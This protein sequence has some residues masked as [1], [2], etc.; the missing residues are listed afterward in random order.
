MAV[1]IIRRRS[2]RRVPT[3]VRR[4]RTAVIAHRDRGAIRHPEC[5]GINDGP[6]P[7]VDDGPQL[8]ALVGDPAELDA[9]FGTGGKVMTNTGGHRAFAVALQSD[10]KIVVAGEGT[11]ARPSASR[12][13]R[14]SG[15]LDPSFDGDGIANVDVGILTAQW[16][17][18]SSPT[19]RSWLSG[20]AA[21]GGFCCEAGDR[22]AD[23]P[24]GPPTARFDSDGVVTTGVGAVL[25]EPARSR[26]RATA[27]SSS[28]VGAASVAGRS[29]SAGSRRPVR[30]TR[31]YGTAGY[32]TTDMGDGSS[33]R[34][35]SRSRPTERPSRW[36]G[37]TAISAWSGTPTAGSSIPR[38][39]ATA[40]S[41][42]IRGD[43]RHGGSR[44]TPERR[45]DRGRPGPGTARFAVARYTAAG[46]LD[47]NIRWRRQGHDDDHRGDG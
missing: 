42:R 3:R 39:T 11:T 7:L 5:R 30:S 12:A 25:A 32:A 10:G 16:T 37:Q 44:R 22:A 18:P 17:W 47:S 24:T 6:A 4:L 15:S 40:S 13:T 29:R 38:S 31:A 46:A 45:Q 26:S 43:H 19:A 20:D 41:R 28:A 33:D 23:R 27:R 34:R 9:T 8:Q 1:A 36:A 14:R 21:P 2:T 35:T